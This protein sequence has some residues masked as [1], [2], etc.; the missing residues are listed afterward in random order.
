MDF[1]FSS[2]VLIALLM[3]AMT[4]HVIHYSSFDRHQKNWYVVTFLCVLFCS[5][6]EYA[7]H[8]G[9][10]SPRF[11]VPLTILTVLQFSLAP[12]M[13]VSFTG[14]LGLHKQARK[15]LW[16][17][18]PHAVI[19]IIAAPFGWIFYFAEDGYHRGDFFIIY[20]VFYFLGLIYLM[21]SMLEV[22]R[23]FKHRDRS[24]IIMVALTLIAGILPVT[25]FNIHTAY[26]GIGMAAC[27]CYI[28]YNDLVQEDTQAELI[29]NQKKIADM[30]EHMISGLAS[31]IESRDADTGLHVSRTRELV[32]LISEGAMQEGVDT[33][34]I[35]EQYVDMIYTLAPMHDVGKIVVSD[36]IL[37]KPARLTSEEF[38][39]MKTHAAVGGVIVRQI[40][41][42]ITEESY[43]KFASDIATYH[44]ERWDGGGY[45]A[46]LK[47]EEIPLCARI[48]AIADVYDAL[49][50]ERC[51][52]KAM[53]P[54]E[55]AA[56]IQEESGT[57]FDPQLV[58]VFLK[59]VD[60]TDMLKQ[61]TII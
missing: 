18:I 58:D 57:H 49:T 37:K 5:L 48:M 55:A 2:I 27:L 22:G 33:D 6:A 30:Q 32:K 39:E 14:A 42:G 36:M 41:S 13:A 11:A 35:D 38:E 10:Y 26:I 15:A 20:S 3:L 12:P 40:L 31:I 19:E 23:N 54:D 44:H 24:T 51:Y 59:Y 34:E 47:G 1:Y 52:K 43:L 21:V 45:P 16:F 4:I 9:R 25:F 7:V 8:C 56:V 60:H 50:S 29:T 61:S 53:P 17:F 28:Y 46:G